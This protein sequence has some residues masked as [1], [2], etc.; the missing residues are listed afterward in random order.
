MIQ[1]EAKLTNFSPSGNRGLELTLRSTGAA[2]PALLG[3]L[4]E[5]YEGQELVVSLTADKRAAA[6]AYKGPKNERGLTPSQELRQL[7]WHQWNHEVRTVESQ[8]PFE[9]FYQ[10]QMRR[11][12]ERMAAR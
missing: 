2:E 1:L 7:I 9:A 6:L 11:I 4:L 3:T 12:I 8:E 5:W 10:R